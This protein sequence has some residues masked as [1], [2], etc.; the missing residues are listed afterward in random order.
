[1][2]ALKSQTR[3]WAERIA[4][5]NWIWND[6]Y[7][8]GGINHLSVLMDEILPKK[9][10]PSLPLYGFQFIFN[11]QSNTRLGSDGYDNYQAPLDE[12][13][14]ELYKRRMWVS[15]S[16]EFVDLPPKA[17]DVVS[18][19]EIVS[20]VRCLGS[21]AFVGIAR[22]CQRGENVILRE[23]RTLLYTNEPYN[24]PKADLILQQKQFSHSTII[25]FT[26]AQLMRFNALSY[27]LHK[28]HHDKT[29]CMKENLKTVIVSGPFLVSVMLRYFAL[30]YPN[31]RIGQFKYKNREPC[32]IDEGV[33]LGINVVEGGYSVEFVKDGRVKC[34]GMI[35]IRD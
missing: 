14:N 33:T 28:I 12:D 2:A 30:I 21:N 17:G 29:F 11:T 32:Y 19:S 25:K 24:D 16:L 5:A 3:K 35:T 27:N 26:L 9:V 18:C 15:G 1:M 4:A 8:I 31:L 6:T 13:G 20:S 10:K 22:E 7:S 23:T 34:G